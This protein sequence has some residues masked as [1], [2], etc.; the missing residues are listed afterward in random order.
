MFVTLRPDHR[1]K[2]HLPSRA[3]PCPA[4]MVSRWPDSS[5][6]LQASSNSRRLLHNLDGEDGRTCRGCHVHVV[7]FVNAKLKGCLLISND[8]VYTLKKK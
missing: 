8:W 4:S 3:Q 6:D 1:D 2:R 7:P 5:C